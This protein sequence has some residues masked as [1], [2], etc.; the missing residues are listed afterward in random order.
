MKKILLIISFIIFHSQI[1]SQFFDLNQQEALLLGGI[2]VTYI[3]QTAYMSLH[4]QPEFEFSN[5]GIGIDLTLN[6]NDQGIRTEEWEDVSDYLSILR[7]FRYGRK[8]DPVYFR[9][10]ALDYATLGH[11]TIIYMYNNRASYDARQIGA[12]FDLDFNY[13]GIETVYSNFLQA[14]ILGVRAYVR[15]LQFTTLATVP[16]IGGFEIGASYSEDFNNN[17][18]I[19][20]GGLDENGDFQATENIGR[21][22][23]YGFD[24]E[25]PIIKGS[26]FEL[27]LFY[28]Y[29][30]IHNF[31]TGQTLGALLNF[32]TGVLDIKAKFERRFNDDDYLP[33]YFNPLYEIDRFSYDAETDSVRSKVQLLYPDGEVGK[34]YYGGLLIDIFHLF[35]ILGSYERLDL[36]PKSGR[37][38]LSA[39]I[40]PKDGSFIAR[41]AYDKVGLHN[42][43]EIFTLDDRS[44]LYAEVGYKPIPFL[45]VSILYKWNFAPVRDNGGMIIGYETQ[46]RVEPRVSLAY[47]FSLSGSNP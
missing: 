47:P 26:T 20:S 29:V 30:Q 35:K 12:E 42:V 40:S 3:D 16:I 34:G 13:F 33:S 1:F 28:D 46:T 2:G 37:L 11:G 39:D 10:G 17:S 6:F 31:G 24:L 7:Y 41:G 43:G 14:G 27:D 32:S 4:F 22:T 21:T 19:V 38:H 36:Y 23:I 45:I 15:P 44:F 18:G 5:I 9:V 8:Y 25:L